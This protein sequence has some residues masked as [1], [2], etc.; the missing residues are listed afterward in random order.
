VLLMHKPVPPA[1]LRSVL[2][3]LVMKRDEREPIVTG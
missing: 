1:R 2:A 3:H